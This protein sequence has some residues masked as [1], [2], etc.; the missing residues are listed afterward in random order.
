MGLSLTGLSVLPL[1]SVIPGPL[2]AALRF[3]SEEDGPSAAGV[4]E[5]AATA[6]G[7]GDDVVGERRMLKRALLREV[8]RVEGAD[9]LFTMD[10]A[11]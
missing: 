4:V 1:S 8:V 11:V 9:F 2:V 7:E 6:E 3:A 5:N 10:G